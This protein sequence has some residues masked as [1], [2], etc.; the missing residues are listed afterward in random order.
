MAALLDRAHMQTFQIAKVFDESKKRINA[1]D[2]NG[3][4]ELLVTSSNDE[5]V[6]LYNVQDAAHQKTVYCKKYGCSQVRF[7]H[8]DDAVIHASTK[9]ELGGIRYLSLHDNKYIRYFKGHKDRSE[10]SRFVEPVSK[11]YPS[12]HSNITSLCMSP[13]NDQFLSAC[14]G[15]SVRLWD[16]KSPNCQA[17]LLHSG[18]L[19]AAFDPEGVVFAIALDNRHIKL[20]DARQYNEG[21][22]TTFGDLSDGSN[23][24]TD[25]TFSPDGKLILVTTL[26]GVLLVVDAYEGTINKALNNAFKNPGL[27]I[28]ASWSPDSKTILTGDG[29]GTINFY[30]VDG[31]LIHNAKGHHEAST[32]V[33]YNPQYAMIASACSMLAFWLPDMD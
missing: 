27:P 10:A 4:G 2:F 11:P 8:S 32:C 30:G 9:T 23:V 7:T 5:A 24:W 20:Y 19:L 31:T 29:Q 21:P 22:F 3:K 25:I 17:N 18:P 16:L 33:R 26:S 1:I 14:S 12:V 28:Q 15:D 13:A 6:Q